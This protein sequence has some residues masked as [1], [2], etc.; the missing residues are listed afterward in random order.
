MDWM[1]V[2]QIINFILDI[3]PKPYPSCNSIYNLQFR[4]ED[5]ATALGFQNFAI[6]TAATTHYYPM[7]TMDYISGQA[8]ERQ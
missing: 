1:Q 7:D 3:Y 8:R 2:T 6:V 4:I 5:N